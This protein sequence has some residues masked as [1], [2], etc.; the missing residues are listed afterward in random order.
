MAGKFGD[1]YRERASRDKRRLEL[2]RDRG[3]LIR[4]GQ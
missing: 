4:E 2:F 1:I 3:H